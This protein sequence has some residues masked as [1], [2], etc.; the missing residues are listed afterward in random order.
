MTAFRF[1]LARVLELRQSELALAETRFRRQTAGLAALDRARAA[2][3]AS[4]IRAEMLVRDAPRIEGSDLAALDAFR[5]HI[6]RRRAAL[7]A[8]RAQA[9][10][11]LDALQAAMLE[12]RR[13]FRLLERLRDRRLAE[14]QEAADR[15]LEQ[16]ASESYLA[17]F[18]ARKASGE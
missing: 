8:S 2:L 14:W 9:Q 10:R 13:R 16:L 7:A 18:A 15:E 11:E 5:R 1:R 12:A 3:D 6:A 4:G 17:K